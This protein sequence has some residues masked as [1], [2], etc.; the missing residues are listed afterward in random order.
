MIAMQLEVGVLW[1]TRKNEAFEIRIPNRKAFM[2]TVIKTAT[3][4]Y[5]DEYTGSMQLLEVRKKKVVKT[6]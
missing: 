6:A 4:G 3:K 2:D 1:N 5:V